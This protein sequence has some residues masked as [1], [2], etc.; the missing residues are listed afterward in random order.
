MEKEGRATFGRGV[1]ALTTMP[2]RPMFPFHLD[3]PSCGFRE[4]PKSEPIT[5]EMGFGWR[6]KERKISL[7]KQMQMLKDEL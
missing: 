5:N 3:R 7:L 1:S 6:K 4:K 2:V